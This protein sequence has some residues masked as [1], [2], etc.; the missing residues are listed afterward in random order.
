MYTFS[1]FCND[2]AHMKLYFVGIRGENVIG[3]IDYNWNRI[4]GTYIG[5]LVVCNQ[6]HYFHTW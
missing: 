6:L 1:E 5:N 4:E 3:N 2:C